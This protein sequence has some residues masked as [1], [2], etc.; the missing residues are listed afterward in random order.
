MYWL[1]KLHFSITSSRNTLYILKSFYLLSYFEFSGNTYVSNALHVP[2]SNRMRVCIFTWSLKEFSDY[3]QH[4]TVLLYDVLRS[5]YKYKTFPNRDVPKSQD[6]ASFCMPLLNL[7]ALKQIL[8]QTLKDKKR[9]SC[10]IRRDQFQV[11]GSDHHKHG[12]LAVKCGYRAS[13]IF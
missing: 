13:Y 9:N 8:K 11:I 7:C 2:V 5:Y 10:R 3:F 6:V 4:L 12:E 1:L